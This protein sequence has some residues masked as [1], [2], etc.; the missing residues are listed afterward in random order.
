[1]PDESLPCDTS[2][3]DNLRQLLLNSPDFFHTYQPYL[4]SPVENPVK[5]LNDGVNF[6]SQCRQL[7]RAGYERAHK[8][9][10]FY[11]LGTA[12][13]LAHDYQTAVFFFDAAVSE[14]IRAGSDPKKS[15]SPAL[16]F[17][18]IQGDQH[19]QAALPLVQKMEL[20]IERAIGDY[21]SRP[22]R[23]HG[24]PEITLDD[25]R[26]YF[27]R[28]VL[29]SN[30]SRLRTLA[31]TFISFFLEWTHRSQLA[32]LAVVGGTAEPFFLHLLKGCLLF[33]SLLKAN[34]IEK[35][36]KSKLEAL[37]RQFQS[38]L[39]IPAGMTI[40]ARDFSLIQNAAT[41]DD[42]SIT[43]AIKRTGQMRNTL[44]HNLGWDCQF[45][46]TT[47]TVLAELVAVSCLHAVACLYRCKLP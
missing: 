28:A 32:G 24:V 38:R 11:W 12:A 16:K 30:Q 46:R 27:L 44:A 26:H 3:E 22:G 23:P 41:T 14:D 31:T 33:E 21:N 2:L 20:T 17:L 36:T 10:P 40:S 47:Y 5:V 7:E 25:I 39:G 8:G 29:S 19:N 13:F 18:Y 15:D 45:D 4:N 6:L 43:V 42:K 35:T 9:T 1:M 37:L 34:P